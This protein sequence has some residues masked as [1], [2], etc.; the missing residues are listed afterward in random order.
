MPCT[1]PP[2]RVSQ[3]LN[4][5]DGSRATQELTDPGEIIRRFGRYLNSRESRAFL[6]ALDDESWVHRNRIRFRAKQFLGANVER[7]NALAH[8]AWLKR[9]YPKVFSTNF[10]KAEKIDPPKKAEKI[11]PPR[12]EQ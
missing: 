5:P 12:E 7:A 1:E 4:H 9:H 6:A 10:K 3:S 11:D 8:L 2:D